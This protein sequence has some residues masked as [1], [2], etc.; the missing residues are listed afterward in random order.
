ML[1]AL[2]IGSLAFAETSV[3]ISPFLA[4]GKS[5]VGMSKRLP[6][7]LSQRLEKEAELQLYDFSDVPSIGGNSPESYMETCPASEIHNCAMVLAQ[8]AKIQYVVSAKV[9][10]LESGFRVDTVI[11][12]ALAAEEI[13]RIPLDV[14]ENGELAFTETLALSLQSVIRNRDSLAQDF[15]D[16]SYITDA[17]ERKS[18]IEK[19]QDLEAE[20]LGGRERLK[21]TFV[22]L[23]VQDIH[24]M[25]QEE[26][27][28]PW[29]EYN[30]TPLQYLQFY[31][32]Q[33]YFKDWKVKMRGRQGKVLVQLSGG[34]GV[35]PSHGRYYGY[36][37]RSDIDLSTLETYAWQSISNG[38][39]S[40]VE[41]SVGIGVL[42]FLDVSVL[43]GRAY[44]RYDVSM[45]WITV[46]NN[47]PN[48][49]QDSLPNDSTYFGS[50]FTICPPSI[51]SFRPSVSI[52]GT[53]WIGTS[54]SQYYDAQFLE[55][56]PPLPSPKM[57]FLSVEPG[58][59]VELSSVIDLWARVP[60]SYLLFAENAP[61][62]AQSL[63][64]LAYEDREEPEGYTPLGFS[65]LL[66]LQFKFN[67][68]G[69]KKSRFDR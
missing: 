61:T 17:E 56:F 19:I 30:M 27:A 26:G 29:E 43:F 18:T 12:D 15:R 47:Q 38:G 32:S 21:S 23:T 49:Q 67:V 42:P 55:D 68:V 8:N 37:L 6:I 24:K 5:A 51:H 64:N 69:G 9:M 22:R 41:G 60:I 50:R 57:L 33:M 53:Y 1:L 46:G 52:A 59:E 2:L 3:L 66:G 14:L 4:T 36:R 20:S 44:S 62:T 16:T 40:Q 35:L 39:V 7:L 11:T 34:Y 48:S 45:W 25:K 63:D 13:F 65:V 54:A 31:N 10:A 28:K 58:G